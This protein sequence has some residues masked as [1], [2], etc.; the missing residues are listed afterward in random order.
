MP[1]SALLPS[2]VALIVG[3]S[4]G[5]GEALARRLARE[6]YHVAV[7]GRRADRLQALCDSLNAPGPA[8]IAFPYPH[9]VRH[10]EAVPAT[11]QTVLRDLSRLDVIIYSVGAM[12][13][14]E[15]NE[16]NF[17]KDRENVETNLL[18][19]MAWLDQA[20]MYFE[21]QGSGHIVGIS[22]V[23]GERGRVGY[24]GYQASK[25][26]LTSFL[27]SL[28]NRL[29]RKGV[30]VLTVKPGQVETDMLR[31]VKRRMWVIS[32][33]Q[34]ANDIYRALHRRQQVLFTPA[35]WGLVMLI[36][37]NIP[38]FIFRRMSF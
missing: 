28:R 33:E 1:S 27:E 30:H 29:T 23:A 3:A 36:I 34:A 21:R 5:L 4:S 26:G 17:D 8:K 12:P 24:P 6:G 37:R 13:P 25:A 10:Y 9:D 19:A 22:S 35:C 15:L 38:S 31:N 11:F 14:V 16:Y 7:L 2:P 20:A 18:G 32:P